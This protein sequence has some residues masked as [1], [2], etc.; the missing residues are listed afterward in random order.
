MTA[1]SL[2][3]LTC[4][5]L[6][7]LA[8]ED[9]ISGWHSMRKEDLVLALVRHARNKARR[10]QNGKSTNGR[11]H[12]KVEPAKRRNPRVADRIREFQSTQKILKLIGSK[13]NGKDIKDRLVVM[14][15]DPYWLHA[16]WELCRQSVERAAAA[17]GQQW[18]GAKP[19]LR[20]LAVGRSGAKKCVER[21]LREIPIHGGV[22]DW[23]I[24]VSDPPSSFQIEIGYLSGEQFH[25]L[26]RSNVV[27]TPAPGDNTKLDNNWEEV[28]RQC[29]K[30]YAMSGGLDINGTADE[31]REL[32]E[33]RLRRPMGSP[34]VTRF[35]LGADVARQSDFALE[36]DCELLVYGTTSPDSH[37]SFRGEPI[38][39][40]EDGTFTLR[41]SLPDRRQVIPVVATRA[42]GVEQRTIVLAVERNTKVMETLV[43][44]PEDIRRK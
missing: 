20:L 22:N 9:G 16:S 37:V 8:K 4:K 2:R 19:I 34:L 23:Y 44:D 24:D 30:I 6:A 40:R 18:H 42:D 36:V 41:V 1:A 38:E 7:K 17:M 33:E 39:I 29:E 3:S 31:L 13:E 11:P 27:T 5:D 26:A 15:R 28:A 21:V 14:V 32:F 10:N 43:R 25:S 35:G 12:G